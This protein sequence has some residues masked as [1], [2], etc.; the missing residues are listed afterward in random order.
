LPRKLTHVFISKS[1]K[2]GRYYD[3]GNCLHLLIKSNGS[4]F[5]IFRY[6]LNGKRH[7]M[8]LGNADRVSLSTA[9]RK[10]LEAKIAL[11]Q[12]EDPIQIRIAARDK[13]TKTASSEFAPFALAY[14]QTKHKEWTTKH[15]KQWSATLVQYV[16]PKIGRKSVDAIDTNDIL[17]ILEPIWTT[18]TE[19]ATRVRGRVEK[20]LAA[21][22]ARGLR[23]G[24]NPA[25][26]RG[27]LE[28]LLSAPRKLKKLK[29]YSALPFEQVPIFVAELRKKDSITALALEFTILTAARTGEVVGAKIDEV[30]GNIWYIPAERMKTRKP[31]R[32]PLGSRALEIIRDAQ[33]LSGNSS[34][35]FSRG[36][37]PIGNMAML[38]M[39]KRDKYAITVH[40]FRSSFRDWVS[41][42]TEYSGE[43]AEMAL[44]HVIAN[45][46]EAAYRRGD[47]IDV[48]SR[49]MSDWEKYCLSLSVVV[50]N[51]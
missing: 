34:Y 39:I 13:P 1:K 20:I 8:G 15:A 49:L 45:K 5:F 2:P 44:A 18:T 26:W 11:D 36:L 48:R 3:G 27:H 24:A 17:D 51:N 43:V 35:I 46:A 38:S 10:A 23:K 22:T 33:A 28:T 32:V 21:A 4:K 31:H 7:D 16:F 47:L 29:H 19:T 30:R 12:G 14:I 9:R 50:P 25:V 40:G 42:T 41:E 37:N 6:Q